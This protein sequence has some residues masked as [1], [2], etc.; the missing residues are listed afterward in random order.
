MNSFH[1]TFLITKY[2][3]EVIDM[4]LLIIL[5]DLLKDRDSIPKV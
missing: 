2:S 4:Y 5:S 3:Q 1:S